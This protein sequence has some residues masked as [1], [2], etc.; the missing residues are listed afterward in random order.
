MSTNA[1]PIASS[2]DPDTCTEPHL[3][4][5]R[6]L[7]TPLAGVAW[8]PNLLDVARACALCPL[9]MCPWNHVQLSLL[10][11]LLLCTLTHGPFGRVCIPALLL[12]SLIKKILITFWVSEAR[13]MRNSWLNGFAI[14]S[15]VIAP[16][17][18]CGYSQPLPWSSAP[19]LGLFFWSAA[20]AASHIP[21]IHLGFPLN[22]A[23]EPA[24]S[25]PLPV[26]KLNGIENQKALLGEFTGKRN[27]SCVSNEPW[28]CTQT[29]Q[30]YFLF[31]EKDW[32]SQRSHR[33]FMFLKGSYKSG[34]KMSSKQRLLYTN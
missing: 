33:L 6:A 18:P 8:L 15:C 3:S 7:K 14:I 17:S 5:T 30:S 22:S 2:Y 23:E 27:Y 29:P 1:P 31:L 19:F 24:W 20:S 28:I 11:L 32:T 25:D 26:T 4:A 12:C 9:T 34:G 16:F 21:H 10:E 13:V